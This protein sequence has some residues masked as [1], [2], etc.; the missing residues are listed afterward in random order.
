MV[1][2]PSDTGRVTLG[3]N[4]ERNNNAYHCIFCHGTVAPFFELLDSFVVLTRLRSTRAPCDRRD[5][6]NFIE[7]F[8]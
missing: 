3:S 5:T 6:F 1:Q 7:T 4:S 8:L 2:I